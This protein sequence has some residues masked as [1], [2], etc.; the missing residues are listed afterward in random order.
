MYNIAYIA[1]RFSLY[2]TIRINKV[3]DYCSWNVKLRIPH[4]IKILVLP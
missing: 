4:I 3:K 1:V 2:S